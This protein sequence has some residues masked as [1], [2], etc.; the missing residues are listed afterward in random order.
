LLGT[1]A[2]SI[3]LIDPDR[4]RYDKM[5]EVG[6]PCRLGQSFPLD[7]GATGQAF[8][9]RRPVVIDDYSGL[10]GGHLPFAH[11]ASHGAVAAV[12]LWWRD[13]VIAVN[14]A[15]AGRSRSFDAEELDAFELLTQS[16]APAVV[17][18]GWRSQVRTE[19]PPPP[20]V[21]TVRHNES[22]LTD[23]QCQ[24]LSL[25]AV[26]LSDRAVAVRLGISPRT[27]EKHVGAALAKTGAAS[28][29]AAV[30]RALDRGWL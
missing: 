3:S 6:I 30:V 4:G 7:E 21:E 2:G 11:P 9:R 8:S 26:G 12:P 28:R 24:V 29:T 10:H 20:A 13:E 18:G 16:V 14:V 23:R 1:V 25:L 5:A 27:V 19:P 17:K 15:F 22:P